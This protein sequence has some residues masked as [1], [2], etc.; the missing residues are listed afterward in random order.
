[1]Q[2]P[3]GHVL[4][5]DAQGGAVFH[6]ADVVDVWHF[7]TA[8]ALVNPAHHV[9]QN[10][11]GVVVEF[12]ALF[13]ITPVGRG[14]HGDL[15]QG[16]E[17]VAAHFLGISFLNGFF[18]RL[19]HLGHIDLV[20]VQRMQCGTGG[21]G[22]PRGVGTGQRVGDF[23]RHHGGHQV[24]HGP[25]AFADLRLAAQPAGQADLH[26]VFLVRCNPGAAFHVPLADHRAGLHGGVHLVA[27][28]V[29]KAG[30]DEGHARAGGGDAGHQ[31]GAGAAL[32][33]HDAELDG[34]VFEA[35]HFFNPAKQLGGK[36]HFSRAVHFGFDDVDAAFA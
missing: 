18:H 2:Q 22:H 16:V 30:V 31:V 25:H 24:G 15:Q 27:G 5:A 17:C 35:Q 26:V 3:V 10:A 20:V 21:A 32:F 8:H 4:A 1:M 13:C 9:A 14:C 11:L 29:Q 33:V 6:Q 34:A 28:A 19:L 23:L 7:A 36:R 12:L